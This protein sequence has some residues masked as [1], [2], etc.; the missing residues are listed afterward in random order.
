MPYGA[1]SRDGAYGPGLYTYKNPALAHHVAI[2]DA[3][4]QS[5]DTNYA[6]IQCRVVTQENCRP[7][8]KSFCGSIDDSGVAFCAQPTAIIPT[9]LLMYRLDTSPD[10]QQPG[11]SVSANMASVSP[12][13]TSTTPAPGGPGQPKSSTNTGMSMTLNYR[14]T[15][16]DEIKNLVSGELKLGTEKG[17]GKPPAQGSLQ[18]I[19]PAVMFRGLG[20]ISK[21]ATSVPPQGSSSSP[22]PQSMIVTDQTGPMDVDQPNPQPAV[23]DITQTQLSASIASGTGAV[24]TRRRRRAKIEPS[25]ALLEVTAAAPPLPPKPP[26]GDTTQNQPRGTINTGTGPVVP[27]P[28]PLP[29]N[30]RGILLSST[31]APAQITTKAVSGIPQ[32]TPLPPSPAPTTTS[33]SRAPFPTAAQ[34]K[35]T[36]VAALQARAAAFVASTALQDGGSHAPQVVP[37]P[38]AAPA[39]DPFDDAEGSP[40][41]PPSDGM[42]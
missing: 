24:G 12:A 18:Y 8:S 20:T 33:K 40:F 14:K 5:R 11:G 35:A 32:S 17:K 6:L 3:D 36:F 7:G 21:A 28:P 9:H 26:A 29:P 41:P 42:T 2:S 34:E 39:E 4:Q 31:A 25:P 10:I 22:A 13:A 16:I 23:G 38:K 30:S 1:S 19:P 37:A 27:P 15:L